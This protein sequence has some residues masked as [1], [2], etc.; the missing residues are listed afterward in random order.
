M[1]KCVVEACGSAFERL[2]VFDCICCVLQ[3]NSFAHF[4]V[5]FPF[6]L[7]VPAKCALLPDR[8]RVLLHFVR[9]L[10]HFVRDLLHLH[11]MSGCTQ[12][13]ILTDVLM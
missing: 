10:L 11:K 3:Q 1:H 5:K 4:N 2:K 7:P 8:V 6:G 9:D 12:S 13:A